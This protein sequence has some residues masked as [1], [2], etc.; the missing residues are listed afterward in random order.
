MPAEGQRK[1]I[2]ILDIIK[3][4]QFIQRHVPLT[5]ARP[6]F[7]KEVFLCEYEDKWDIYGDTEENLDADGD[8][9]IDEKVSLLLDEVVNDLLE[10]APGEMRT[11]LDEARTA[12][13]DVDEEGSPLVYKLQHR[14]Q[15]LVRIRVDRSGGP[16]NLGDFPAI[17][18][19]RFGAKFVDKIANPKEILQF[20]RK[21]S[22]KKGTTTNNQATAPQPS[23]QS[24]DDIVEDDIVD[25][26][27]ALFKKKLE[28][29]DTDFAILDLEAISKA[30]DKDTI[31]KVASDC[32]DRHTEEKI[33]ASKAAN[34]ENSND[35]GE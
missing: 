22:T 9:N 5:Q 11:I 29:A 30:K 14:D 23:K 32:F 15:P 13:N 4:R 20:Y 34:E 6:F 33:K 10:S 26:F 31:S 16:K 18:S 24:N 1:R 28:A 8:P 25:E 19:G 7:T 21:K 17:P 35:D 27:D 12:G 2:S 3:G